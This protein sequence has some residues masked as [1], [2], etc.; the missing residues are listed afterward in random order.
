MLSG[1][2]NLR[3]TYTTSNHR[4][5]FNHAPGIL[6]FFLFV[7]TI[8]GTIIRFLAG[9]HNLLSTSVISSGQGVI[10]QG[11]N[12]NI[13]GTFLSDFFQQVFYKFNSTK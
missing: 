2:I 6:N 5:I 4:G 1:Q 7:I 8:K 10:F 9:T 12:T 3:C 11:A 13:Y